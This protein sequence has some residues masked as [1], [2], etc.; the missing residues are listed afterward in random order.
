MVRALEHRKLNSDEHFFT[1]DF[2]SFYTKLVC[3]GGQTCVGEVVSNAIFALY[4]PKRQAQLA[5]FL[6]RILSRLLADSVVQNT[7][8]GSNTL[9]KQ[10]SGLTTGLSA[11]STIA[12]IY[13]AYGYDDCA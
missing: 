9:F 1:L 2:E 7:A 11:A 4:I 3:A 5:D 10:V 12:N 13:F 8:D 6:V